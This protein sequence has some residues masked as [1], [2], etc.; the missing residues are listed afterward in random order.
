MEQTID[1]HNNL[2]E[3]QRQSQKALCTYCMIPFMYHLRND[4]FKEMEN[5]LVVAGVRKEARREI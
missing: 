3:P 5:K 2:D 1:S 4:I